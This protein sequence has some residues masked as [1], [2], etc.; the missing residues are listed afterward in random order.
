MNIEMKLNEAIELLKP[1]ER[2]VPVEALQVLRDDWVGAEPLLLADLDR[3]IE[4]SMGA[5]ESA[6]FLYALYLCAEMRSESAFECYVRMC[7]MPRFLQ[8]N[9]LGDALCE[10]MSEMLLRTCAGRLDVLK[11]LVEDESVDEYARSAALEALTH[12][13]LD[14]VFPRE[15]A[16]IY[17]I[18]LLGHKLEQRASYVWNRAVSMAT[19]LRLQRASGLIDWAY[20]VGLADSMFDS[21]ESVQKTLKNPS[22]AAKREPFGITE[23]QLHRYARNWGDG[24]EW[25]E[26]PS[27]ADLLAEPKNN[28]RQSRVARGKELGRNEPCPCGS[29]KKYKKCCI[30]IGHTKA[31][32]AE[33]DRF[34]PRNKADEWI[35][36]G[37]FY[38]KKSIPRNTLLCWSRAWK[39]A[40]S[41]LPPESKDSDDEA[42][43]ALF[44]GCKDFSAWLQD[45]L[46]FLE[47]HASWGP[48]MLR[49][50]KAFISEVL[51]RFPEMEADL[52]AD[53]ERTRIKFLLWT[54]ES[55][56][57]LS[58]LETL[59]AENE[60]PVIWLE[61]ESALFGWEAPKYNLKSDWS[62]V[63]HVLEEAREQEPCRESMALLAEEI[64]ELKGLLKDEEEA[65]GR[66]M[67]VAGLARTGAF[68]GL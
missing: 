3:R 31:I 19:A 60:C 53:F 6:L 7:R 51:N 25:V 13:V 21:L 36:A 44:V 22:P 8:D 2:Q 45:Y 61:F 37:Y 55:E 66:R 50:G 62:R 65:R 32:H 17:C 16:E 14:G 49:E 11:Q 54:G 5:E 29:G 47:E 68:D 67:H 9:L 57:A 33:D 43:D 59:K 63:L 34:V 30:S 1:F 27:E 28:L 39:E 15:E 40:L 12:L 48:E 20:S 24:S 64:E 35:A 58:V 10:S 41:I 23:D 56:K 52:W 38:R 42:C 4:D 46:L 18:D 26:V